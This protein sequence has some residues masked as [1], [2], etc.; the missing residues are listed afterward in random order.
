MRILSYGSINIDHVYNVTHFVRPGET[1]PAID[2]RT[3]VGGKG[4]NQSVALA[5]AGAEVLH[6]GKAGPGCEWLLAHMHEANVDTSLITVGDVPAGHAIIQVDPSG[7]NCILL[8]GGANQHIESSEI[9]TA[10][11]EFSKGDFLL[12]QNEINRIPELIRMAKD[13]QMKI[14]FNPAPMNDAVESYPLEL[15]DYLILNEIEGRELSGQDRPDDILAKLSARLPSTAIVLTLGESGAI[16]HFGN[17]HIA[18]PAKKVKAIDTTAAGDTFTGYFLA[19]LARGSEVNHALSIATEAAAICVTK[20]GA[21]SSIPFL[22][23]VRTSP[24]DHQ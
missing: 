4:L 24:A 3:F 10:L 23:E 11:T 6:A 20:A 14:V 13:R 15:V 21:A 22:K 1:L 16:Y 9:K 18:V 19:E 5:R 2:Y 17:Q 8:F 7:Q 12:L